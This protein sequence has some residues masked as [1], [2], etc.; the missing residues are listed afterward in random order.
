MGFCPTL[1]YWLCPI[2]GFPGGAQTGAVVTAVRLSAATERLLEPGASEWRSVPEEPLGLSPTPLGAQPSVYVL[3]AW[4][5]RPYG[6]LEQLHVRA[7]HNG[8]SLL[9]R[10]AWPDETK[11]DHIQD[12]DRFF[13]AAAVL[14]PLKADA[15]LTSMGSP[16]QPVNGWYWRP[17]LERPLNVTA[18]GLGSTVRHPDAFLQAGAQYEDGEWAVVISRPFAVS[19]D[20]AAPLAPGQRGKVGFAVWQGSNQERA[21]LKAVTLDWQPLEIEG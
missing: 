3:V 7:A 21:G 19:S 9:F 12:T 2:D 6:L 20:A 11:D 4:P 10:L 15:A 14:F 16:D 17:D 5:D 18:T 13:D 1:L 8:Q